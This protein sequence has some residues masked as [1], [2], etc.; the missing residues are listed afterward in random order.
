M[1][2]MNGEGIKETRRR[3]MRDLSSDSVWLWG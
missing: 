3:K 1:Q 2:E